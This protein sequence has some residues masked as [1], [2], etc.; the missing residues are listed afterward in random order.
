MLRKDAGVI[1]TGSDRPDSPSKL[2]LL[3]EFDFGRMDLEQNKTGDTSGD[4]LTDDVLATL[5]QM[6]S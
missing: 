3:Q 5:A 6:T 1:S 2:A 4:D